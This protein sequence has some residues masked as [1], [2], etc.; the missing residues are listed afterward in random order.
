MNRLTVSLF[1]TLPWHTGIAAKIFRFIFFLFLC[2]SF[3]IES[4]SQGSPFPPPREIRVF[5]T[6]ELSFGEFYTGPIGG[7]V[8]VNP[9]GSRSSVGTVVLAGGF[10]QPAVF[11]VELLPGRLVHIMINPQSTILNRVGGGGTMIMNIGPTDKGTSFVTSSGHP[12]RN[13]VQVGGI[14]EVGNITA[15]PAGEYTGTFNVTFIQ[16]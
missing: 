1:S 15:N 10:G 9:S 4:Y 13:P 11:I 5:G 8:I 7:S 12:F 2:F 6:Q 3:N 14:L 16:E